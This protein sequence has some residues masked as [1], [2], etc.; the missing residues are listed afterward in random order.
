MSNPSLPSPNPV[1]AK[2]R[3]QQLSHATSVA[4]SDEKSA[5]LVVLNI[6]LKDLFSRTVLPCHPVLLAQASNHAKNP[7]NLW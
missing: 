6:T 4:A 1:S 5:C 3:L 7:G 2:Y